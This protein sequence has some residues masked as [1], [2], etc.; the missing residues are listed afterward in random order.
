MRIDPQEHL[1]D[2]ITFIVILVVIAVLMNGCST[3]KDKTKINEVNKK[4]EEFSK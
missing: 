1:M 2:T 4:V 3:M